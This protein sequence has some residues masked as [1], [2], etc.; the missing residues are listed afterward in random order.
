MPES[1]QWEAEAPSAEA[2]AASPPAGKDPGDPSEELLAPG[3]MVDHFRVTK[4]LARGGMGE[5]YLARDTRLG[6][7]VALKRVHPSLLG[8]EEAIA[9]FLSEARATAKFNHPNIVT[10]YAV[11]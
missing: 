6:R 1:P 5:V 3:T 9:R 11:G 4:F 10:L 8:S 2:A 7:K